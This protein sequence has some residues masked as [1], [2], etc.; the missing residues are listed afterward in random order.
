[1]AFF[2]SLCFFFQE[3]INSFVK[4]HHRSGHGFL[5]GLRNGGDNLNKLPPAHYQ[6]YVGG[7]QKVFDTFPSPS[8]WT[9]LV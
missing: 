4:G 9:I 6:P 1:M 7:D 8:L 2:C 3:G 5:S